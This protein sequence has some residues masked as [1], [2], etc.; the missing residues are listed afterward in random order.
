LI[1]L[2]V[3]GQRR[4]CAERQVRVVSVVC[5]FVNM[6]CMPRDDL[7]SYAAGAQP[8]YDSARLAPIAPSF[9]ARE[10]SPS[11]RGP[12]LDAGVV[13]H[14]DPSAPATPDVVA[15]DGS[16]QPACDGKP[17]AV[18]GKSTQSLRVGDLDRSFI[19]YAPEGL[20]PNSPAPLLIV[21]HGYSV[22]SDDLF[23][24]TRRFSQ[25]S[26][27]CTME[28]RSGDLPERVWPHPECLR[29]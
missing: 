18:R 20:D 19:Y 27:H 12:T 5:T 16:C 3:V 13:W 15:G 7:S 26:G 17:G 29:R 1:G 2:N 28:H 11:P 21:A 24:I 14:S 23:A 10:P 6:A 4:G 25:R 8:E 22:S 9:D